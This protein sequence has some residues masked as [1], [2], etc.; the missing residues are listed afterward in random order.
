MFLQPSDRAGFGAAEEGSV[1]LGNLQWRGLT[2]KH[3]AREVDAQAAVLQSPI[4]DAALMDGTSTPG[5]FRKLMAT[6]TAD[7]VLVGDTLLAVPSTCGDQPAAGAFTDTHVVSF[8]LWPEQ[9]ICGHYTPR[10]P[11]GQARLGYPACVGVLLR[12]AASGIMGGFG[13]QWSWPGRAAGTIGEGI[14]VL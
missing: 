1:V 7:A 14:W 10:D 11:E 13:S 5:G 8:P 6:A 3:L 4:Q 12:G 9:K 2:H